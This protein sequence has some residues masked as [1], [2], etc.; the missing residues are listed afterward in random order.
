MVLLLVMKYCMQEESM[1]KLLCVLVVVVSVFLTGC[2]DGPLGDGGL[3]DFIIEST[4]SNLLLLEK[5]YYYTSQSISPSRPEVFISFK[6][7]AEFGATVYTVQ[8]SATGEDGSGP[9]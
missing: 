9:I 2:P 4:P 5:S 3:G 6:T 1:K 8:Y 7:P